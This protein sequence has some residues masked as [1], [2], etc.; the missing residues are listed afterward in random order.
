MTR[1]EFAVGLTVQKK[2]WRDDGVVTP[3]K[4]QNPCGV[5]WAFSAT[6][7]IESAAAIAGGSLQ[8]LSAEQIID[9]DGSGCNGGGDPH[10]AFQYVQK[11][12][13][14]DTDSAYP[15]TCCNEKSKNTGSC[16]FK[17]G[18]GAVQVTGI[19]MGPQTE[20]ELAAAVASQGP[21]SIGVDATGWDTYKG[22]IS[23]TGGG[24]GTSLDHAVA[25]IGFDKTGDTPYWI[26]RNQWG[27]DWGEGGYMYLA[28]GSN[29]C[30][31]TTEPSIPQVSSSSRAAT[32][33]V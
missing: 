10:Q 15:Q 3:I 4:D 21:F 20:D 14:L 26:I 27:T 6:G 30:A 13:G 19:S 32:F 17:S 18:S 9:C 23:T 29:L 22:G 1:D 16:A 5:C 8:V 12:G 33:V 31:L 7:T 2:D 11:A 28:M 24:C 25:I